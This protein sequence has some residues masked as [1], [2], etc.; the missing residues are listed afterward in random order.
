MDRYEIYGYGGY[1][2]RSDY[3]SA[4]HCAAELVR[5]HWKQTGALGECFAVVFDKLNRY[6]VAVWLTND[7][8]VKF[9]KLF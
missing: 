9:R 8:K 3:E 2:S 7:L 6:R 5:N 4:L 1:N